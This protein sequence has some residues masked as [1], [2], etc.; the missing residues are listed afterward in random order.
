[1]TSPAPDVP[2]INFH[3]GNPTAKDVGEYQHLGV[4]HVLVDLP[5]EPRDETLRRLD[6]FKAEFAQLG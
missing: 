4:D 1:M 2:V 3:G 6:E 5:T